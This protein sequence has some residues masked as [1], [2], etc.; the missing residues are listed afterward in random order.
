M[1]AGRPNSHRPDD[2]ARRVWWNRTR[3]K[4]NSPR[5]IY[6]LALTQRGPVKRLY[7]N[8]VMRSRRTS[9]DASAKSAAAFGAFY[10]ANYR[11]IRRF[12]ARMLGSADDVEDLA[13]E[14]FARLWRELERGSEPTDPRAWLYKVASNLVVSRRRW[15]LRARAFRTRVEESARDWQSRVPADNERGSIYRQLVPPC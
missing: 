3:V 12:I 4:A 1:S 5:K 15:L 11:S 10:D 6:F 14:T 7:L 8:G 2:W 9:A 13:Q